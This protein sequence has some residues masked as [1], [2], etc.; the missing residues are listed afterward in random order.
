MKKNKSSIQMMYYPF[1]HFPFLLPF[2]QSPHSLNLQT[3]PY[4]MVGRVFFEGRTVK[5][6]V[7]I[8]K[9]I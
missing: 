1:F 4:G 8:L 9:C 3:K 7:H 2:A 5:G 6:Q